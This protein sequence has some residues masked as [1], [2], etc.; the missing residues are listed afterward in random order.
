M[1]KAL[2][3][4]YRPHD[5]SSVVGQDA[6]I[7]TLKNSIMNNNFSHAYMFFGPRGVGKT[8][9]SKILARSVNCLDPKD[10]EA[11]GKCKNCEYS[12]DKECVDIIEIDAASN[13]GVDEIRDLRNKV[14][15][16]PAELKYK[17]YIIDEVHM[18]SIGAFNALLK[19]LEEPPEHVIFIL[20]TTDPQKVPDTI[21]SRCQCFSFN[22]IANSMIEKRLEYVCEHENIAIDDLVLKEIALASDGGLR[23]ALGML[24]KLTS[25]TSEKIT[26]T[27]FADLNGIITYDMLDSFYNNI[28][29]GNLKEVLEQ[30]DKFNTSGKNLVQILVQ[31]MNHI[32]NLI[33]N[34]YVDGADIPYDI[35]KLLQ[36]VN[37]INEKM[38][39]IKQSNDPK[40]Y[41]EMFLTKCI[42]NMF[43]VSSKSGEIISREI[44]S[45]NKACGNNN[46]DSNISNS[47]AIIAS[48][49]DVSSE[50]N[51]TNV[52]S[53]DAFDDDEEYDF[54]SD[55]GDDSNEEM[56][57]FSY[58]NEINSVNQV[59]INEEINVK[60]NENSKTDDLSNNESKVNDIINNFNRKIINIDEINTIRINNIMASADKQLLINEKQLFSMLNDFTFDQNNGYLVCS[61]L[62]GTIRAVSDSGIILSYEYDALVEKAKDDLPK[63]IEAYNNIT[64]S[65]K[66]IA[67]LSDEQWENE[68]SK[69]I[70]SVKSGNHYVSMEEPSVI[71]E[72]I[73][74]DGI[75]NKAIELFG[76]IVEISDEKGE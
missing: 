48:N 25:Y 71:Y 52:L 37:V 4:K 13:N 51:K 9:V 53:N 67:V 5:F 50:N 28:C 1:H 38:V 15:L 45:D 75:I 46:F 65:N 40:I 19:T 26:L 58:D 64:K 69:Y 54:N 7:K 29:T 57:E 59:N 74:N 36:F 14:S 22:R 2:Y 18:L 3:R 30:I 33:I 31:L 8:T 43:G 55:L 72:E 10:G 21:I 34:Y 32:R 62:D 39:D 41:L 66:N 70:E 23:D 24:D 63:M 56:E 16:V 73:K 76:D 60:I 6:I 47:E 11:C 27:D 17:V 49:C 44:K 42:K 68:K 61:L 20:A 12:F 35:D